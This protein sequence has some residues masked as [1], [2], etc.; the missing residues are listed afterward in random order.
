MKKI[1]I[2]KIAAILI[3]LIIFSIFY[4]KINQFISL[5]WGQTRDDHFQAVEISLLLVTL[6]V[7]SFIGVRQ[8]S[9]NQSQKDLDYFPAVGLE[10][11]E[12]PY[13]NASTSKV[14]IKI[15]NL[16]KSGLTIYNGVFN[17]DLPLNA[18]ERFISPSEEKFFKLTTG[19]ISELER[20][21][22]LSTSTVMMYPVTF[23]AKLP[24]KSVYLVRSV[25]SVTS[26]YTGCCVYSI[27]TENI[28]KK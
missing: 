16:G 24:D 12:N 26:D 7:A 11:T 14:Q 17:S 13:P 19:F 25:F 5:V 6:I 9:I 27:V 15:K 1:M 23:D 8:N 20:I 3:I 28:K 21:Y 22:K 4:K 10:I 2:L 18:G